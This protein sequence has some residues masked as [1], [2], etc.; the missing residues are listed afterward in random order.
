VKSKFDT[1]FFFEM[2]YNLNFKDS[3]IPKNVARIYWDY[4]DDSE[5]QIIDYSDGSVKVEL[6]ED[7]CQQNYEE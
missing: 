6:K 2:W 5:V 7:R 4:Y 3:V 1:E